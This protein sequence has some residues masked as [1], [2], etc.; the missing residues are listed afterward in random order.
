MHI[1][2]GYGVILTVMLTWFRLYFPPYVP[3]RWGFAISFSF[4]YKKQSIVTF[5]VFIT[6]RVLLV[7]AAQSIELDE[8][9][10]L[11]LLFE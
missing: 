4:W 10:T 5:L 6:L 8:A 11:Q 7:Y 1:G 2:E 9:G 3:R